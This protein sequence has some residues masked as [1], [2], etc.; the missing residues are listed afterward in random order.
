MATPEFVEVNLYSH[1]ASALVN[2][3]Y[4]GLEPDDEAELEGWVEGQVADY[5][6]FYCVGKEDNDHFGD[7]D[8][9]G[10]PGTVATFTFQ[11]Q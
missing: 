11:V 8:N 2:G 5:G 1:W 10:L 3:D 6:M 4:S 9:G 7:P